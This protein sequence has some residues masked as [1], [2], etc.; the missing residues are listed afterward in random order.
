MQINIGKIE[1]YK[2]IKFINGKYIISWGLTNP[3]GNI[4]KWYYFMKDYKP[5]I[6]DIK[7]EIE[8]YINECTKN[9]IV[10]NFKWNNMNIILTIENQIN[11]KLLF[12]VT[13]LKNGDN[14]PETV[15]FKYKNQNIFYTFESLDEIKEFIIEMN[16]HIRKSIL[17]GNEWKES[18][19]YDDYNI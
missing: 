4:V 6:F 9:N 2:P 1:D 18:I 19:N 7:N 13:M 12:D 11:Y 5:S 17:Y 14:L 16:N 10:N 8:S 15:K 3:E